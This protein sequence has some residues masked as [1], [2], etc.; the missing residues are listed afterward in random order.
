MVLTVPEVS[1]WAPGDANLDGW[2]D[3]RDAEILAQNWLMSSG[4][5]WLEGDFNGD[6][7]VNEIDVTLMAANWYPEPSASVPEPS[8]IIVLLGALLSFALLRR[9]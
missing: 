3:E 6:Y 8:A 7:K 9:R 5:T 2:V 4:A 1:P